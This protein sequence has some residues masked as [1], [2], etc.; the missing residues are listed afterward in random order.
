MSVWVLPRFQQ[1]SLNST[2]AITAL[3]TRY[4]SIIIVN[5]QALTI[6]PFN[7]APDSSEEGIRDQFVHKAHQR[8]GRQQLSRVQD[9]IIWI[10]QLQI[11]NT[12]NLIELKH[13]LYM[14]IERN[15]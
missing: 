13:H 11:L 14:S 15:H 2:I 1:D 8:Q 3:Q 9:P 7:W 12:I 4:Q 6:P 5:H 10:W